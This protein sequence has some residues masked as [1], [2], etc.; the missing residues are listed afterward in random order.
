MDFI[1]N[2]RSAT[3]E[4]SQRAVQI[5]S[6]YVPIVSPGCTVILRLHLVL[7]S[8]FH[9]TQDAPSHWQLFINGKFMLHCTSSTLDRLNSVH[10]VCLFATLD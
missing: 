7:G 1:N 3:L 8:L 9:L 6:A 10:N 2:R 4:V 5:T